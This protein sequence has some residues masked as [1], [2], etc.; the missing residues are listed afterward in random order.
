MEFTSGVV[1]QGNLFHECANGDEEAF[2]LGTAIYQY[3]DWLDN[4]IDSDIEQ[5]FEYSAKTSLQLFLVLTYNKF[6]HVHHEKLAPLLVTA[7]NSWLDSEAL[8]AHGDYRVRIA[9]DVLKGHFMEFFYQIAFITGGYDLMRAVSK[10]WRG[11]DFDAKPPEVAAPAPAAPVPLPTPRAW[12]FPEDHSVHPEFPVEW[13]YFSGNSEDGSFGYHYCEFIVLGKLHKHL[14]LVRCDVGKS[15]HIEQVGGESLID[16]TLPGLVRIKGTIQDVEV[17]IKLKHFRSVFLQGQNQDGV[18]VKSDVPGNFSYYYSI[19]YL[20]T[21]GRISAPKFDPIVFQGATWFDHEF[22]PSGRP[23]G[24][25]WVFFQARF[26]EQMSLTGYLMLEDGKFN[27]KYSR[28]SGVDDCGKFL[29]EMSFMDM[30]NPPVLPLDRL[31]IALTTGSLVI[32]PR[33]KKQ[34]QFVSQLG[35]YLEVPCTVTYG[36]FSG[37]G[38]LEIAQ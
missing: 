1:P 18:S 37:L 26:N 3:I 23:K 24:L 19:P 14:G 30:P 25:G 33:I 29:W 12:K 4:V 32:E 15:C 10:K 5:P 6:W 16:F 2:K 21:D 20:R 17:D 35:T 34:T 27:P 8:R 9:A 38:Y 11:F 22:S 7:Y 28:I 36:E 13:R 31:E